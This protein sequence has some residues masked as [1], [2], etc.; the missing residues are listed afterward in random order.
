M[1]FL[2]LTSKTIIGTKFEW[3]TLSNFKNK[4]PWQLTI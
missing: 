3:V 4:E 2:I 1:N